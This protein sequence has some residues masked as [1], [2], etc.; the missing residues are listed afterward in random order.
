MA[1]ELTLPAWLSTGIFFVLGLLIGSFLN[2]LIHRLPRIMEQQWQSELES[3]PGEAPTS[4][5]PTYSLLLPRSHCPHCG[6]V[7]RWHENLPLLSYLVLRGKCSACKTSIS[8]RYPVMELVSGLLFAWCAVR[9]GGITT[10]NSL[11]ATLA[12]CGFCALLLALALIDWDSTL[13]PD[14]LTQPLLWT[15]LIG[16][17]LGW[18]DTTL[19]DA[20]WG[21]VAGYMSL[22]SLYWVFKLVTGKEGMGHGDF[23]LHAALGAWL[24]WT[25]LPA[26]LLLASVL[27]AVVGLVLLHRQRK[28][29]ASRLEPLKSAQEEP[30]YIPFGPFLAFA[31][32]LLMVLGPQ[33][34]WNTVGLN[35]PDLGFMLK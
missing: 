24:G 17:T 8:P 9:W 23:K 19:P 25:A 7:L 13:L 10:V 33:T 6:H 34:L 22:W 11:P 16:S 35:L 15:G 32:G 4:L 28:E 1:S 21:A 5:R 30:F 29:N 12:W 31:G 18:T 26:L 27:G 3:G 2:V 14:S 20:L